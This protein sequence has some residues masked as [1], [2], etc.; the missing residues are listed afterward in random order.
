MRLSPWYNCPM[1]VAIDPNT[2]EV[3]EEALPSVALRFPW[4]RW[5]DGKVWIATPSVDFDVPVNQFRSL[6]HER[7][8]RTGLAVSTK[9]FGEMSIAFVFS[10]NPTSETSER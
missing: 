2:H 10:P 7:A 9:L 5:T 4:N 8:R 1:A 3:I 6:L